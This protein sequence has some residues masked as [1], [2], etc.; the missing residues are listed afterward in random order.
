MKPGGCKIKKDISVG[1][2][3]LQYVTDLNRKDHYVCYCTAEDPRCNFGSITTFFTVKNRQFALI[4]RWNNPEF[5]N[6]V[7]QITVA[8]ENGRKDIIETTNI[9]YLIGGLEEKDE[10][11]RTRK[12]RL[13]VGA[14]DYVRLHEL[15]PV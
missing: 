7:H 15:D 14:L 3:S 5:D 6:D 13:I 9:Y 1:S 4:T 8:H 10:G 11:H 12:S 2:I